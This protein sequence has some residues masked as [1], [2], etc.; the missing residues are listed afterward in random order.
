MGECFVTGRRKE[1]RFQY[2]LNPYSL[3]K[4]LYFRAFQGRSG[5]ILVD[6]S[7][8]DKILLPDDF[9]EY[10]Y[11]I[12]NAFEM[13]SIVQSGLIPGGRSNRKNR[14]SVFFTAVNPI[15]IQP[16]Q[17]KVEYDLDKPRIA[18]HKHTWRSHYNAVFWCKFETCSE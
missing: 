10:I 12:G 6:P 11:H 18:P 14:Q 5:E 7:L 17:R 8:Q 2:C 15:D 3:N 9:A 16:D 1:K 4:C 13:H